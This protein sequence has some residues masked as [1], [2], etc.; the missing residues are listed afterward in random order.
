MVYQGQNVDT[1]EKRAYYRH[2]TEGERYYLTLLLMNVKG[3]KSCKDL[4]IFN[5]ETCST[6]REF[7]EKL[8]LLHCDNNLIEYTLE[9]TNYQMSHNL[10]CLFA[11]LLVY[12]NPVNPRELWEQF[13]QAMSED[14]KLLP[15]IGR[16][17]IQFKF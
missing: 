3:P 8:D 7:V 17:E 12:C 4:G 9:A 1:P 5:G 13:E 15:N 14:Y 6:F 16:S 11:T 2:P 10:R